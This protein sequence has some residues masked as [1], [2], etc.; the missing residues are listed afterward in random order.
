[1]KLTKYSFIIVL[2][3]TIKSYAF[4]DLFGGIKTTF[5]NEMK[6]LQNST[7]K[8]LS[9]IKAGINDVQL[10]LGKI[11]NKLE[12]TLKM[13]G[14]LQNSISGINKSINQTTSSGR[15]TIT[16]TTTTNDSDLMKH[17]FKII[18]GIFSAL[19]LLLWRIIRSK[20][21]LI[22]KERKL[23]FERLRERDLIIQ[24]KDRFLEKLIMNL[25][26]DWKEALKMSGIF[27]N[28][29]NK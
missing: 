5:K 25:S 18:S 14:Q 27:N 29:N 28:N 4:L 17:I 24:E 23:F 19:T 22:E 16:T 7:E 21:K 9:D 6:K 10:K 26:D 15:D 2:T 11:E 3:L 20:N 13:T 12:I 1:M 8:K